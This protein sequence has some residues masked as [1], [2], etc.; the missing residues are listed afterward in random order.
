MRGR[1]LRGG[2]KGR[3]RRVLRGGKRRSGGGGRLELL[4]GAVNVVGLYL[5]ARVIVPQGLW[6]VFRR[7]WGS[8]LARLEFWSFEKLGLVV[9]AL[10]ERRGLVARALL[11]WRRGRLVWMHILTL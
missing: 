10:L 5:R 11:R 8:G 9:V 6:R 1:S 2:D 4:V 7:C 3:V